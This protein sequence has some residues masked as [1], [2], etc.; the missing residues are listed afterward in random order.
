[1]AG[2]ARTVGLTFCRYVVVLSLEYQRHLCLIVKS[3]VFLRVD[4][5]AI[6]NALLDSGHLPS[7]SAVLH[8]CL[9][10]LSRQVA[11]FYVDCFG[12]QALQLQRADASFISVSQLRQLLLI[13]LR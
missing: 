13:Q 5:Y 12:V 3:S 6:I 7:L 10:L 2:L 9:H 1:M 4:L 11:Y 8:H